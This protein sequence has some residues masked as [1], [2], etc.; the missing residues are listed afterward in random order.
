MAAYQLSFPQELRA[1]VH[2]PLS[3]SISNRLLII[4]A[5]AG[6][7]FHTSSFSSCNDTQVLRNALAQDAPVVDVGAA[8]TAMRFLTA[9]YAVCPDRRHLLTGSSRMKMRPLGLLVDALRCLGAQIGYVEKEGFPPVSIYG[10]QL[11]GGGIHLAGNVSSQFVTALLLVAPSFQYGLTLHVEDEIVSRPYIDLTLG[12]MQQA[13][14]DARWMS[15]HKIVVRPGHYCPDKIIQVEADWSAASYW[16]EWVALSQKGSACLKGLQ[17]DSLQGD[18][19]ICQFFAPLGVKSSFTSHGLLLEKQP[20]SATSFNMDFSNHPDVVQS[21]VVACCLL[22]IHFSFTGLN[23]LRIKETDRIVALQKELRKLGFVLKVKA[24][25]TL[26][27][28]GEACPPLPNPVIETYDDHRMAMAFAPAACCFPH[29]VIQD[30]QVVNKSYPGFWDDLIA[31]K[32]II[33]PV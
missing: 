20:V 27:W 4:R 24:L 10:H 9:Y 2:L 6:G 32:V 3:K 15:L 7:N 26:E 29:L 5:L 16:F 30:P 11:D 14:I 28:H 31:A 21:L 1:V 33:T 22:N 13:G 17:A 8:G 23:S 25:N 12:L 18:K 19:S